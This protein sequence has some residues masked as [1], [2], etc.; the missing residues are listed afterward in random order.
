MSFDNNEKISLLF[1]KL[2]GKPYT[3]GSIEF[4][5]E[6]SLQNRPVIFDNQIYQKAVP[7]S[8]DKFCFCWS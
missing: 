5:N 8:M 7:N 2:V 4:Y 6:P 1:K 3:S